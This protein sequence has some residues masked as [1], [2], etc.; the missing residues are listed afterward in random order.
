MV[1]NDRFQGH[2]VCTLYTFCVHLMAAR[3]TCGGVISCDLW[4]RVLQ[5]TLG[6]GFTA[7]WS[8]KLARSTTMLGLGG[9]DLATAK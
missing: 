4:F 8:P 9:L 7:I 6:Q 1:R 2:S 5:I 3:W